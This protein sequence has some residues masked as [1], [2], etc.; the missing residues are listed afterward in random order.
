MFGEKPQTAPAPT[1]TP[2]AAQAAPAQG[3]E[4]PLA[5]VIRANREARQAAQAAQ[6]AKSS[7]DAEL[8]AAREELA[9]LKADRDA[10]EAD[11]VG[12]AKARKW[13]PEQQ[14]LYGQ[15][16]LYDLAPEKADPD[17]RIKMFEDRQKREA[18]EKEKAEA[19]RAAKAEQEAIQ[20]QVQEFYQDTA[21]AVRTFEAGSYPESEAWFGGDFN[22]YMQ[23][24]MA[25]AQNVANAAQREGKVADLRP[26]TLA[27][28]LEKATASRMAARDARKQAHAPKGQA[29]AGKPA[30]GEQPVDTMSTRNLTGAGTPRPPA[31][32]EKERIERA[33]QVAFRSK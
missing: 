10:F 12:Y 25:T 22:A 13:S 11:P 20:A 6:A 30:G 15:S 9:R 19:E 23:S 3:K 2:P 18:A 8:K 16:L 29:D 27:S 32:T 4:P 14:L 21:A 26:A 7:T 31:M 24:I 5:E 33:A 17:F 1:P 28:L